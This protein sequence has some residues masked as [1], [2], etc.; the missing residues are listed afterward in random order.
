MKNP[1]DIIIS[2]LEDYL[3][4][5][6]PEIVGIEAVNH[7]QQSFIDEGF[8]DK[9]L[10]KWDDVK[11]RTN[12]RDSERAAATRPILTGDTG[13]LADSITYT[14]HRNYVEITSDKDYAL[15]HNEGTTN[16]GRNRNV[17]IKQRQFVGES[18]TLS[19]V[20]EDII[21]NDIKQIFKS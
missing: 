17:T 1:F 13:E 5:T 3:Q 19:K 15:A 16:A 12:A 4:N 8:T 2:Q 10:V 9:E 20:I 7:F 14:A 11:R 18:E 21:K 6:M